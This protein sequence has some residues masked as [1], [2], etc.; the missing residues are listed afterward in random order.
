MA[1]KSRNQVEGRSRI[2]RGRKLHDLED[3]ETEEE[4]RRFLKEGAEFEAAE[5]DE[6]QDK[7]ADAVHRPYRMEPREDFGNLGQFWLADN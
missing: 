6:T 1:R 7:E 5:A 3:N 2:T 4:L